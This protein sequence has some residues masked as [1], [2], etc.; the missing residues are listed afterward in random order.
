MAAISKTRYRGMAW[1]QVQKSCSLARHFQLKLFLNRL[2]IWYQF[3]TNLR[4]AK[5]WYFEISKKNC[6][7]VRQH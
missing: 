4:P 3:K 1:L 2:E 5:R 7:N 6:M